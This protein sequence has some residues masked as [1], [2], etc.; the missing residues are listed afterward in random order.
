MNRLGWIVLAVFLFPSAPVHAIGP[1]PNNSVQVIGHGCTTA[2]FIDA[3]C[4]GCGVGIKASGIYPVVTGTLPGNG[5]APFW[6][7]GDTVD[8]D[9]T[10]STVC[11]KADWQAKW[12]WTDPPTS[13]NDAAN[14]TAMETFLTQKKGVTTTTVYYL[15][16][17]GSDATCQVNKPSLPCATMAKIMTIMEPLVT[18]EF[19][20]T[21]SITSGSNV[22]TI[23]STTSGTLKRGDLIGP[24]GTGIAANTFIVGQKPVTQGGGYVM[25]SNATATNASRTGTTGSYQNGG[26]I[27][28]RAGT[29]NTTAIRLD[30]GAPN[31]AWRLSGSPGHP[32]MVMAY[33]GEIVLDEYS[34]GAQG[35]MSS[36]SGVTPP[37]KSTCCI[38]LDGIQASAGSFDIGQGLNFANVEDV[39][40]Q[41][42]EMAGYNDTIFSENSKNIK[43]F[44]NVF[45]EI[46]HHAIYLSFGATF[47]NPNFASS[48][49]AVPTPGDFNFAMDQVKYLNGL[50]CGAQYQMREVGN[51]LYD[52][53]TSGFDLLHTNAWVLSTY[54]TGNIISYTGG[55]QINLASGNYGTIASGNLLFDNADNCFLAVVGPATSGNGPASNHWNSFTHNV[56]FLIDS[57]L[58][59]WGSQSGPGTH[60]QSEV[61]TIT[62]TL[63]APT[64]MTV[65]SQA[66]TGVAPGMVVFATGAPVGTVV[67][68]YGTN[69]TTGNGSGPGTYALSN[70]VVSEPSET[71]FTKNPLPMADQGTVIQ[72]NI[73]VAT[74][75]GGAVC[76]LSCTNA[77]PID[78][79][80]NSYPETN[81]ITGNTFW[82]V[83]SQSPARI[84]FV[85]SDSSTLGTIPTG[86]YGFSGA[87]SFSTYFPGNTFADPS[88]GN[89]AWNVSSAIYQTPGVYNFGKYNLK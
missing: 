17:T 46:A 85:S 30:D 80:Y 61:C 5:A 32:A 43:Y 18:Q 65:N 75:N 81:S 35:I 88:I 11:T 1:G 28:V 37:A 54:E 16:Q 40:V 53:G 64:T 10:D 26:V 71:I 36:L 59:V 39:T 63:T 6:T 19:S 9:D 50:S 56:C 13:G 44:N 27:I 2:F 55:S 66:C 42:M 25:T 79:E 73:I 69:G 3:D 58:F 31:P 77:I 21:V 87:S 57:S 8:A 29:W 68:P 72:N 33:P 34:N 14:N 70:T 60:Q 15:S 51:V 24:T 86:T 67:L 20:G 82:N 84:M 89:G 4:D 76:A 38:I 7:M 41:N 52:G 74:D 83:G 12:G 47:A 22:L 62:G 49:C 45:H 23:V 78:F 48:Q